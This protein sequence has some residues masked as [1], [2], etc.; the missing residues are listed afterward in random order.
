MKI[1]LVENFGADFVGAR[2]HELTNVIIYSPTIIGEREEQTGSKGEWGFG[3]SI[4][5]YKKLK[6]SMY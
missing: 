3:I 1:A 2:L 5:D 6:F 4:E